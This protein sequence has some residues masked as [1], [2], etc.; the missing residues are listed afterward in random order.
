MRTKSRFGVPGARFA[1][2]AAALTAS[3]GA[4]K[5]PSYVLPDGAPAP[6]SVRLVQSISGATVDLGNDATDLCVIQ[7]V[8]AWVPSAVGTSDAGDDGSAGDNDGGDSQAQ[9]QVNLYFDTPTGTWHLASN[10]SAAATVACAPWTAFGGAHDLWRVDNGGA[11]L[12]AA[13]PGAIPTVTVV[14]DGGQTCVLSDL[15]GDFSTPGNGASI[16]DAGNLTIGNASG[17]DIYASETCFAGAPAVT[18]ADFQV[19]ALDGSV[20]VPIVPDSD[21]LCGLS[22]VA[23]LGQAPSGVLVA[24]GRALGTSSTTTVRCFLFDLPDAQ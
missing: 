4:C 13:Y 21:G 12:V 6:L 17:N 1:V 9:S 2:L 15:Q 20:S 19:N 18:Y 7:S 23:S 16:D 5:D 11:N 10:G 3:A 14:S 24:R 22:A 8:T